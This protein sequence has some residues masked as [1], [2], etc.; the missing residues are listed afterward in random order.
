MFFTLPA[1][2]SVCLNYCQLCHCCEKAAVGTMQMMGV[3]T[4]GHTLGHTLPNPCLRLKADYINKTY[5]NVIIFIYEKI[6]LSNLLSMSFF[7]PL[8][9]PYCTLYP[10]PSLNP[11]PVFQRTEIS[12]LS[13]YINDW[14][15]TKLLW[16]TIA[17][18]N[19][20]KA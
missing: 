1:I 3:A 10:A 8:V 7:M 17:E 6:Y 4:F 20:L 9:L 11:P 19:R 18:N 14:N 12:Q 15:A 16:D 2:C 5:W 13:Y